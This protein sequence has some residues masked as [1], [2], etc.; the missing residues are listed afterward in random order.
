MLLAV[1]HG[2]QDVSRLDVS[3][4]QPSPVGGVE[5]GGKLHQQLHRAVWFQR[6]GPLQNF[7]QVAAG[8]VVHDEEQQS[9][10]IARVMDPDHVRVVKRRGD[11]H[12]ALEPLPEPLVIGELGRED[13][14]RVDPVQPDIRRAV[15]N[16]HSTSADEFVDAIAPDDR[17][18]FQLGASQLHRR[19]F[20]IPL[21]VERFHQA[22]RAPQPTVV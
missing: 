21:D 11:A 22:N 5:R 7:A 9:L 3:V 20:R 16:S 13:L 6:A 15:D 10:V 4:H 1:P 12:L 14:E 19:L 2:N 8:H 18:G 17:A